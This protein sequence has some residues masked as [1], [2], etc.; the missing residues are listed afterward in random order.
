MKKILV[1]I[2]Y[3]LGIDIV[4][5]RFK[6]LV[7]LAHCHR[8]GR[9]YKTPF[10][11]VSQGE[12]EVTII[13]DK[14]KFFI[15]KTS[16]LKSNTYIECNGGVK[17]GEYFHTGRNLTILSSNHNYESATKIPYDNKDILAPVEIGDFVWAGLNV[18]ILAGVK[19]GEG[20]I[21]AAGS[22]ITKDV[23]AMAMVGGVPAKILKYRD[24]DHFEKLKAEKAFY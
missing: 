12:G 1:L 7:H 21:L 19:I 23:P 14:V 18:T 4:C 9:R 11:F 6:K 2:T 20:A 10:K 22:V 17:I 8:L 3:F 16:H 5:D 13:G 15:G 24:K